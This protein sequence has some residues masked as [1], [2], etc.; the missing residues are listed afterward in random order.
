M[1]AEPASAHRSNWQ[2]LS[3]NQRGAVWMLGATIGFTLNGAL[4]KTLAQLDM[5]A[6]QISFARAF[7]ALL[8]I[9]PFVWHERRTLLQ[10]SHWGTHI[11]RGLAGAI[12]MLCGFYA[13]SKMPLADVTALGF[14][15]PLF[16]TLLAFLLLG[17]V[18]RWRRWSA[19]LVGF[20]GVLVI[21]RPGA[22]SF[23]PTALAAL[24]MALGIALAVTL[25]KRFPATESR[26]RMLFVFCITSIILSAPLAFFTWRT[27][28]L[29][30]LGL[31][32][33]I[34]V[35]G[36]ASQSMIIRAYQAGEASFIA[37]FDYSK[38]LFAGL[39]GYFLFGEIPDNW[40]F[41]GAAI[42]V[43]ATLYIL[44]RE[45]ARGSDRSTPPQSRL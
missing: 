33:G 1:A 21:V 10:S 40:T 15:Q 7:F 41:L 35:L 9:L 19:T 37:P 30:E 13:V 27:P 34:G 16:T 22:E 11:L 14:T 8:A 45:S 6:F 25:V 4:V 43:G 18:V 44:R 39:I 26:V 32:L 29:V 31:L 23:E 28:N 12:A 42:I 24:A 20:G 17:E 3:P 36:V 2:R 38:L 5:D